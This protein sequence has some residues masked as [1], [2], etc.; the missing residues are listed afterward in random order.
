MILLG[1]LVEKK[2]IFSNQIGYL[3]TAIERETLFMSS[4]KYLFVYLV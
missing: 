2:S 4:H 3:F 1:L